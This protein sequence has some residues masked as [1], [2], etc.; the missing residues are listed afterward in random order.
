MIASSKQNSRPG[1][2]LLPGGDPQAFGLRGIRDPD[3]H[4]AVLSAV[5]RAAQKSAP[6]YS[7]SDGPRRV[8]AAAGSLPAVRFCIER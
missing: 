5:G 2:A 1:R 6:L 4:P 8:L 3:A 7:A